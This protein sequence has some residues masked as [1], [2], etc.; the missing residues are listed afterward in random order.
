MN[1]E[2]HS[3]ATSTSTVHGVVK[4]SLTPRCSAHSTASTAQHSTA[5]HSTAQHSTAGAQC[6]LPSPP[7]LTQPHLDL[8]DVVL[9]QHLAV[10]CL[11]AVL[12]QKGRAAVT[13]GRSVSCWSS[14]GV[15][16]QSHCAQPQQ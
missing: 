15:Q 5:Q 4:Q 13:Q 9:H 16:V 11:P 3:T 1:D 8:G 2:W 14:Y 6:R 10:V 7:P 12:Q